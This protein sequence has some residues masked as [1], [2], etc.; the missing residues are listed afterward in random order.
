MSATIL[1]LLSFGL[2]APRSS[3]GQISQQETPAQ[4][5]EFHPEGNIHLDVL[6]TDAS[7]A[8]ITGLQ[9]REFEL[10]D[11][12]KQRSIASFAA[13]DG[14]KAKPDP[15]SEMIL[16]IDTVNNGFVELGFIR[17][18]V[19]KFLRQNGGRL[20]QPVSI[21][22]LT[23][24][25]VQKISD[26]SVDGNALANQVHRMG[27]STRPRGIDAFAVSMMA[28]ARL[29]QDK[30]KTPGRKLLIWLGTGWP[31]PPPI[32]QTFTSIEERN[33]RAYY[34]LT[35]RV[36]TALREGRMVLYGGY[37]GS[38]FYMHDY[39]KGV[40]KVSDLDPRGLSLDVLAYK[41]GGRGELPVINRGSDTISLLNHFAEEA[42]S[43]YAISFNPPLAKSVDEF[44][45]LKVVVDK[46]GLTASTATGYYDEPEFYRPEPAPEVA[47]IPSQP[48]NDEP[49]APELVTVAQLTSFLH[50]QK[51]A[52]D[53]ELTKELERLQLSERLSSAKLTALMNELPGTKSKNALMAIGD[54]SV[55]L[56]PP[57][58][59]IP[60]KAVPEMA[61]QRQIM[62]RVVEYLNKTVPRLPDFYARRLTTSFEEMWT[63]RD[64]KGTHNPGVLHRVGE[65]KATVYYRRGKEVVH[66]D[67]EEERGLT[68][69]GTFGPVLSTVIVDAAYSKTTQWS[70]WEEGPSGP[71]A[72]F[73]FRVP[74]NESHYEVSFPSSIGA[75]GAAGPIAYHGEIGV[76]PGSG[77]ILRLLLEAD[78]DLGSSMERADI[79][80][81]YGSVVIGG[82]VYTCPRRSVSYSMGNSVDVQRMG[83]G[84]SFAREVARL[85][86][87]VFD[88]YHVFRSEIKILPYA[89]Q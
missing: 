77:T 72:V 52:K 22:R 35:I 48:L 43:F 73:R 66:A 80:V 38:N 30:A 76:D 7:G 68:T 61:Q 39:L 81:E 31:T 5:E 83:M 75:V 27:A 14:V 40:R 1:L 29:S 26:A 41:S 20:G 33:R 63:P 50:D 70:R 3:R 28:L 65:F 17:E 64:A 42:N 78:P 21:A 67:G 87:V 71:M 12:G 32:G 60:K 23:I 4:D 24:S 53:S 25:G 6:V 79:M 47:E 69:R 9:K 45:E 13:F 16:L 44:H 19:E 88:N 86:D 18:G 85:N 57:D 55:F 89:G 56:A 74:Q 34:E 62:S 51:N 37:S 8:P 58:A 49:P 46:P 15:P 10:F 36:L 82:K 59:E 54:S 84:L 11:E 2:A